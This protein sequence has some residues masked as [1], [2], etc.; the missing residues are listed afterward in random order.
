MDT[1]EVTTENEEPSL[2]EALEASFEEHEEEEVVEE[3][4]PEEEPASEEESDNGEPDGQ[5]SEEQEQSQDEEETSGESREEEGDS[6]PGSWKPEARESWKD[7]PKSA[8]AEIHRRERELHDVMQRS[9]EYK[10]VAE[11]F[12]ATVTPF[13][14]LM[15][16][17]G[18]TDP[19]AAIE[20][21]CRTTSALR[22]GTPRE[23]A[24]RVAGLISHYGVDLEELDGLL[25]ATISGDEPEQNKL[26]QLLQERLAPVNEFMG[27]MQSNMDAYQDRTQQ[28]YQDE[29]TAFQNNP[30]NEFFNDVRNDVADLLELAAGRGQQLSLQEAYDKACL[31]SPEVSKVMSTRKQITTEGAKANLRKKRA[32]SSSVGGSGQA[33]GAA[34]TGSIREALMTAWD[35]A[36]D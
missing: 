10:D 27:R 8:R 35:Q 30:K 36:E 15:Q 9:S 20:G 33:A 19:F 13:T 32:A 2:R 7:I 28:S 26:D 25:A 34:S 29:I 12:T 3:E 1:E 5:E 22:F 18:A 21:L 16:A 24:Q 4:V 17:E 23:K 31:M 14:H 11:R 6:V